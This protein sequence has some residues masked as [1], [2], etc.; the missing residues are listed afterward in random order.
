M[1]KTAA[2]VEIPSDYL[3]TGPPP[4][5]RES[6]SWIWRWITIDDPI[7]YKCRI[8]GC[9]WGMKKTAC[10]SLAQAE[11]HLKQAHSSTKS[12]LASNLTLTPLDNTMIH[13]LD[14]LSTLIQN[15]PVPI[16]ESDNRELSLELPSTRENIPGQ[17]RESQELQSPYRAS[18]VLSPQQYGFIPHYPLYQPQYGW[19]DSQF[20]RISTYQ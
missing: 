5:K 13:N 7:Y 9:N 6:S 12:V 17:Y 15:P 2:N 11:N 8:D 10:C 18:S 14:E 1:K 16:N 3:K 4:I 19:Y 20:Q